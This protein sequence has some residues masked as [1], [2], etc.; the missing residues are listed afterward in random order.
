MIL[1]SQNIIL[2]GKTVI[3]A[4]AMLRGDLKRA[5]QPGSAAGDKGSQSNVAIAIGRY[6][7]ISKG[8]VLKPPAK[9]Y[10]GCVMLSILSVAACGCGC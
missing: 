5:L 3:Q 2:G 1:G 6:C 8:V 10:K 7:F 4:D 9:S